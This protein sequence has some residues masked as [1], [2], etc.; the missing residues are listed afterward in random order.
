MCFLYQNAFTLR[1]HFPDSGY[2][3]SYFNGSFALFLA[4]EEQDASY[5]CVCKYSLSDF[6]HTEVLLIQPSLYLIMF[7]ALVLELKGIV[8]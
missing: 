5:S 3:V 1:L 4:M 6:Q 2:A 8:F 7:P